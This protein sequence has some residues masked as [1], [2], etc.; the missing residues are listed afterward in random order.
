MIYKK[1]NKQLNNNHNHND[2][3]NN[4][5]SRVIKKNTTKTITQ[6]LWVM[7]KDQKYQPNR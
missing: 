7:W 2:N 3:D 5:N 6:Y 1:E 4:K